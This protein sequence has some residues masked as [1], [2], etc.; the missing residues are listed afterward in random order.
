MLFSESYRALRRYV[1]RLVDS[2]EAAE[3]IAQ[4]AFLRIYQQGDKVTGNFNGDKLEG[5]VT[6]NQLHF[7]SKD[8]E[9]GTDTVQGTLQN[10]TLTEFGISSYTISRGRFHNKHFICADYDLTP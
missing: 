9:G 1:R 5:T 2:Q 4:E 6:G 3:D 8:N 7:V 10:G